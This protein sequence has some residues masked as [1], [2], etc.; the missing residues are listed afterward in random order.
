MTPLDAAPREIDPEVFLAEELAPVIRQLIDDFNSTLT[1]DAHGP[2][3]GGPIGALSIAEELHACPPR[4]VY[5]ILTGESATVSLDVA[6]RVFLALDS[7]ISRIVHQGM[8]ES[9]R[10]SEL[11]EA[12]K[13]QTELL[14]TIA[15]CRGMHVPPPGEERRAWPEAMRRKLAREARAA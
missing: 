4:T 14:C 1:L 9:Y 15:R 5:R 12:Q 2:K 3:E 6:D 8:V 13:L 7:N 10:R 11:R